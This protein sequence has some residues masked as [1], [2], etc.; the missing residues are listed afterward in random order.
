MSRFERDFARRKPLTLALSQKRERGL[1]SPSGE[2]LGMR[3]NIERKRMKV[4]HWI[5]IILILAFL[6]AFSFGVIPDFFAPPTPLPT[7]PPARIT[8]APD[9][10]AAVTEFLL[11][12]QRDDYETM[13][14]MLAKSSHDAITLEDFSKRW[15]TT[16]NE[17]SA[18]NI[19][20]VINSSQISPFNAEV[21]YGITYKTVLAGDIQR[22]IV[23]RLA[24]EEGAWKVIWDDSLIMPELAGGNSVAME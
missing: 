21:G 9:A 17:M 22:N 23:M 16:L 13:Y 19:E 5:N 7:P 14:A 10:Q 8:P 15:N 2:G 20:F 12:L 6:S 4:L 11:S 18:A 24:N 1:P 3:V